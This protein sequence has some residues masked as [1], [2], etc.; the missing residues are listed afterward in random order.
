MKSHMMYMAIIKY[1]MLDE[2]HTIDETIKLVRHK[3]W[4]QAMQEEYDFLI[5]NNTLIL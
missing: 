5:E 4:I 2:L 3:E 1:Y